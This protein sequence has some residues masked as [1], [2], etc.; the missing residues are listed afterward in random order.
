MKDLILY[1]SEFKGAKTVCREAAGIKPDID[2]GSDITVRLKADKI[3][4]NTVYVSGTIEGFLDLQCSRCLF[5]YKHKINI[6]LGFDIDFKE[7][8]VDLNQEVR[9][10]IILEMPMKP[11]CSEECLGVCPVC[12]RRNKKGDS[13]SCQ[14]INEAMRLESIKQKWL[15]SI[16]G[17]RNAKSKK[18]THAAS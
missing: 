14:D 9:D 2:C 7:G 10:S 5:L 8:K 15:D 13:C 17:D 16:K 12:G 11:L 3:S 18:E 4:D 1:S 6:P